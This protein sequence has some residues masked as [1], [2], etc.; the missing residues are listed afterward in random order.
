VTLR[1][2]D[3]KGGKDTNIC[4]ITVNNLIPSVKPFGPII[5]DE[6]TPFD[7]TAIST[8]LGSDDLTFTWEFEN[9]PFITNIY[10][11]DGGGP[12][13]YPSPWGIYP[14]SI[15]DSVGHTYGD[16]GNYSI[17]LTITDDDGGSA[18]YQT[19]IIANNVPPSIIS[20]NHTIV[21]VNEPRTIGYWGHQCEVEEPYGDHI[22]ILQEWVDD[23]SFQSKVFSWITTEEDVCSVVQEGDAKDMIVMAKRQ[24]MGTWLNVVSEKLHPLSEIYMP[25]LTSSK[26]VWGAIQEIEDL[27]L[28]SNNRTE[29]ERVKDIA[30]NINNGIGI[31]LAYVEFTSTATDPGT[32]DL[33]FDWD[34]GDAKSEMHFYPNL[35]GTFPIEVTDHVG[36]SY[37]SM[38]P[39]IT[40]LT[41]ADD[42]GGIT[43]TPFIIVI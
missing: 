18:V 8:D 10:Y 3:D 25:N 27:I 28:H 43:A 6:G 32:D 4:N 13:P 34:F 30:D 15:S 42:D 31:A 29:L 19:Y 1:V 33:K 7:I 16:D 35:N 41:V 14:F 39:F 17:T 21:L 24:F 20:F 5:I 9:G 23:I 40:T 38:G 11:N 12:D 22:G 36:H 37:L 2:T 26:I